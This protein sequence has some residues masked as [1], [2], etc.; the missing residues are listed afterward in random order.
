MARFATQLSHKNFTRDRAIIK[1]EVSLPP[2]QLHFRHERTGAPAT[3]GTAAFID[4]PRKR[5]GPNP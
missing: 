2:L 5:S 4:D 1:F 3:F